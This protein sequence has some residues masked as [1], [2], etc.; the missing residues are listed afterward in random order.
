[1]KALNR[2]RTVVTCCMMG[3]RAVGVAAAPL[4]AAALAAAATAAAA[5]AADGRCCLTALFHTWVR[6]LK[7]ES[8][9]SSDPK[10]CFSSA[11]AS[12]TAL[13]MILAVFSLDTFST[14]RIGIWSCNSKESVL[15]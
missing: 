4:A 2:I 11:V 15:K 7:V 1:M 3:A 14:E 8:L 5:A 13:G 6:N 12:P 9:E 10:T